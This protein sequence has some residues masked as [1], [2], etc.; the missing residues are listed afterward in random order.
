MVLIWREVTDESDDLGCSFL[1]MKKNM[2]GE[3]FLQS[4][5]VFKSYLESFNWK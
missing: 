5:E 4:P 2:L 3:H 1:K